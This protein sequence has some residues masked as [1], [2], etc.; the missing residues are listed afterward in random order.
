[1]SQ[2]MLPDLLDERAIERLLVHYMALNDAALYDELVALFTPE[3]QLVRPAAPDAPIVGRDAI[4]AAMRGRPPRK[5]RHLVCNM[6]V[7]LEAPD[8]ARA[9]STTVLIS[10]NAEGPPGVS[11]GGF[12]D[13][14]VKQNGR[15]LFTERRGSTSI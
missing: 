5:A 8:R 4:L 9:T 11:V 2:D 7:S 15:W 14:L 13:R 12:E 10:A 3:G 1:M 6:M